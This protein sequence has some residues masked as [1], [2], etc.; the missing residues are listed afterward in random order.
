MIANLDQK[1]IFALI[2]TIIFGIVAVTV[3]IS[4]LSTL[5]HAVD[6]TKIGAL[7]TL[8]EVISRSGTLQII[9]VIIISMCVFI[10]RICELITSESTISTL[11]GIAGFV[12]G[13]LSQK[14]GRIL[15]KKHEPDKNE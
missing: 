3:V 8:S 14:D 15:K 5:K 9:T 1:Y 6:G 7:R 10:L 11:T 12:L 4:F 13:G 2:L